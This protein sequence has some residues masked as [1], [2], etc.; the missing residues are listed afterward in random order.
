MQLIWV[1]Q[2]LWGQQHAAEI[3][4][5]VANK[6]LLATKESVLSIVKLAYLNHCKAN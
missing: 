5:S 3:M 6:P 1:L 4:K 2:C